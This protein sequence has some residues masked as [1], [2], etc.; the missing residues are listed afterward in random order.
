MQ[1][2]TV[3]IYE[4]ERT[5]I[6]LTANI[7]NHRFNG[8]SSLDERLSRLVASGSP[9]AVRANNQCDECN[10]KVKVKEQ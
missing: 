2:K 1:Q 6:V 10:A 3:N 8:S 9:F 5:F 4:K 7:L